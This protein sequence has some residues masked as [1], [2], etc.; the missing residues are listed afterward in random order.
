VEPLRTA[1][2]TISPLF[3]DVLTQ[4]LSRCVKLEIIEHI[5]TRAGLERRLP[6]LSLDLVLIGLG[7]ND[8][9]AIASS[10]A[11]LLPRSVVLAFSSDLRRTLA[12][13]AQRPPLSLDDATLE[14]LADVIT[15][16]RRSPA[17]RLS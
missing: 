4:S 17:D 9:D 3:R 11:G 5:D 10:I 6:T 1:T 7:Q 16:L 14:A 2:V 15:T 13:C 8:G 12:C